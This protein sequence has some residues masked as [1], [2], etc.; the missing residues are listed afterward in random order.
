MPI[1]KTQLSEDIDKK[2][3]IVIKNA[4][5]FKMQGI[6]WAISDELPPAYYEIYDFLAQELAR[7]DEEIERLEN[8]LSECPFCNKDKVSFT[9]PL[10]LKD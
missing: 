6:S 4:L 8:K 7:K 3:K 10:N 5:H 1:T 2:L 9:R